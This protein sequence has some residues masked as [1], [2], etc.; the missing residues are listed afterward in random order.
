MI[1]SLLAVSAL[2]FSLSAGAF[3]ATKSSGVST[4]GTP[5]D[6]EI[7]EKLSVA[8]HPCLPPPEKELDGAPV[9][10]FKI[11]GSLVCR[12]IA[13]PVNPNQVIEY[14]CT[15]RRI[16]DTSCVRDMFNAF[17]ATKDV[18]DV[19]EIALGDEKV[20]VTRSKAGYR[21]EYTNKKDAKAG[22]AVPSEGA[23][24]VCDPVLVCEQ[25]AALYASSTDISAA[26]V[27]AS[28]YCAAHLKDTTG[29][30]PAKQGDQREKHLPEQ[31][32]PNSASPPS[33]GQHGKEAI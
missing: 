17:P 1:R 21:M 23:E 19:R 9:C 16:E 25:L 24:K 7:F 5:I 6:K 29:V 18:A 22:F 11:A 26:Q 30:D 14:T 32:A 33:S 31:G 3:Q 13:G 12:R 15:N 27:K 20:T 2:V 8:Q 10:T 28:P 4:K